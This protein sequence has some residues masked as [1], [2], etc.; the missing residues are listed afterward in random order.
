MKS[1]SLILSLKLLEY[2]LPALV[3]PHLYRVHFTEEKVRL[4][5][6]DLVTMEPIASKKV[7]NQMF[8]VNMTWNV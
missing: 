5:D 6:R 8:F 1:F 2:D 7:I 4:R 3:V